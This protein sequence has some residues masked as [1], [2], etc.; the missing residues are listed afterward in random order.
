MSAA[1]IGILLSGRYRVESKLGSGGMS[2]VYLAQDDTLERQVAVKI[3]HAEISDQPEQIERFRREALAVAQLSHPNIVTV[4]DAGEDDGHPYIVFE[5]VAGETLKSRIER[6]G[7]LPLDETAAY[8]IEIGRGLAAAHARGLVHRDVKPQNVLIDGEGRAKVTDF[9]I[10]RNLESHGLTATGRVLGTTDYLSPEQAMGQDVDAR[11]DIYSLGIVIYEMVT[12]EV[13][14][15]AETQVGVAMKHVNEGLPEI[16]TRR[17]NASST[18]AAVLDRSTAKTADARYPDMASVLT[19]LE[20]ALEVEVA[21]AGHSSGEATSVLASVPGKRRKL[22]SRRHMSWAGVLMVLALAAA[23]IAFAAL[24]G[25]EDTPASVETQD[26]VPSIAILG[27]TDFDPE[28]GDGELPADVGFA[29][30]DDPTGTPWTTEHYT[31]DHF[32]ALKEGVGIYVDAGTPAQPD[33]MQVQTA[34]GG[35]S[36]EVYAAESSPPDDLA[37]WGDPVGSVTDATTVEEIPLAVLQPSQ[38]F[39]LWF[40]KLSPSTSEPDKFRVEVDDI[41]L[42]G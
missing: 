15:K 10:A 22:L 3:M 25:G 13:P 38:Y 23:A 4:I 41:S 8:G 9:G 11:S 14:F 40:T 7:P 37:D 2:T 1:M 26:D 33:A 19:D 16:Q 28:G 17:S 39:L 42:S 24:T 6:V 32:G 30:D 5:Y 20:T 12:G 34:G 29:V 31:S 35:W 27:A 18:I 21:R 36:A